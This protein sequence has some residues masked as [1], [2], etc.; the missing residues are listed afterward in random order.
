ME[1]VAVMFPVGVGCMT[2]YTVALLNIP[3]FVLPEEA[4]NGVVK[5]NGCV[6]PTVQ[7]KTFAATSLSV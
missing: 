3:L 7:L 5:A 2:P 6:V 4:Q 1:V